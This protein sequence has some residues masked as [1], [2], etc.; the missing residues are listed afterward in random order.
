MTITRYRLLSP[1]SPEAAT[2]LRFLVIIRVLC[3]RTAGP[4]PDTWRAVYGYIK[5][6]RHTTRGSSSS[7]HTNYRLGPN[8][9]DDDGWAFYDPRYSSAAK[10]QR[11]AVYHFVDCNQQHDLL[12]V[13]SSPASYDTRHRYF[14]APVYLSV[15]PSLLDH[16]EKVR[17]K[18]QWS[19]TFL[20]ARIHGRSSKGSR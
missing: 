9:D 2:P 10:T 7:S 1:R 19:S 17:P 13:C 8:Y 15:R 6:H 12:H 5:P 3:C 14:N 16:R 20:A 11:L 4:P 18:T